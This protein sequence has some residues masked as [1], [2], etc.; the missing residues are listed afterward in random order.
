MAVAR[1]AVIAVACLSLIV[2]LSAALSSRA[3]GQANPYDKN[4][5][6][7]INTTGRALSMSVPLLDDTRKLGEISVRID[8]D[9]RIWIPRNVFVDM[10]GD[11]VKPDVADAVR[12]LPDKAG[13]I[14]IAVLQSTDANVVF[15]KMQVALVLAPRADARTTSVI[16]LNGA[17]PVV[18]STTL[19][20]PAIWS[21]FVNVTGG[22]DHLWEAGGHTARTGLALELESA[23]RYGGFVLENEAV[24]DGAVNAQ[25]CPHDAFC[26]YAH[27][28]GFK[29][30][31]TRL[32]HDRP[33]S[34]L[35]LQVG[36]AYTESRGFQRITDIGGIV[37]EKAPHKLQP[38]T[39]G[40]ASTN[41]SFLLERPSVVEVFV[42]GQPVRHLRLRPGTYDLRDL[43]LVSGSNRLRLEITDDTGARRTLE[44]TTFFD[45]QLLKS[46][47]SEWSIGGG[48]PSYF[49]D[50]ERLYAEDRYAVSG[51]YR[52]GLTDR[53]TAEVIGQL[54]DDVG[55]AGGT[56][57]AGTQWG[58]FAL[59]GGFSHSSAGQGFALGA[60]WDLLDFKG[61]KRNAVAGQES[62]R[63][64]A[65][66]RSPHFRQPGDFLA[67]ANG[68]LYPT[69]NYWLKLS[70]AYT[71]PVG[72]GLSLTLAGRYQFA[73]DEALDPGTF[74]VRGDRYGADLMLS[75][76]VYD[77]ITG[78]ISVGYSNE[79]T[80]RYTPAAQDNIS[81]EF[82]VMA[83]AF[84]HF[85]GAT[86]ASAS[87]DSLNRQALVSATHSHGTGVGRWETSVDAISDGRSDSAGLNGVVGYYGN[88]A[89]ARL[90]H[91]GG[92]AS[93]NFVNEIDQ[94]RTS[95]RVG[96]AIAFADGKVA[97]GA[98]IR[99]NAFA[100]VYPHESLAGKDILVGSLD[101]IRAKADRFGPAVVTDLPAYSGTTLAI[102]VADLPVGYSLGAG[103]FDLRPQLRSGYA[104]EVGSKHSVSAYGTLI[105]PKGGPLALLSGTASATHEPQRHVPVMT[106]SA[107]RFAAEGLSPGRWTIEM[108]AEDGVVRY[109]LEVPKGAD[110]LI[111][112]GTLHPIGSTIALRAT[113]DSSDR[114]PASGD[115]PP[116]AG[117]SPASTR[118][119]LRR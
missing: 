5:T 115:E 8:P 62:L 87:Y 80:L 40:R 119:E 42:N 112:A 52:Y 108:S 14:D 104:L 76:P 84:I 25:T 93:S 43:A 51:T 66:Y 81:P 45:H 17:P 59:H 111:R 96:S 60:S 67:T 114:E 79:A 78:S 89:E 54:D 98:P 41:Q 77:R 70:G 97:V 75:G 64:S 106:N 9:D 73:N 50:S 91:Y 57:L 95:L 72:L 28:E 69:Y 48:V 103:A 85:G 19:A 6:D 58:F 65:E 37:L 88:R 34:A 83:R 105:G 3:L 7:Q 107:G 55:L 32:I 92:F 36:D 24:Y 116:A 46:G 53:V 56:M 27:A 29:R 30:R 13:L 94:Q 47:A 31:R 22:I 38:D 21:G 63:L 61:L 118:V 82:R 18:Q 71:V 113:A 12:R 100:I 33:E 86:H 44:W 2:P 15:D 68:V 39:Y 1:I 117:S 4:L 110:G 20:R 23:V 49:L 90:S 11:V 101:Q 26:N 10:L 16:S 35:R 99:G 74:A 102:D 109:A